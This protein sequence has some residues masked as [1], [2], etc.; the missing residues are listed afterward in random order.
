MILGIVASIAS[1]IATVLGFLNSQEIKSIKSSQTAG[2][3]AIQNVGD[4]ARNTINTT[5]VR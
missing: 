2:N 3:G 5:R 1:I 4:N